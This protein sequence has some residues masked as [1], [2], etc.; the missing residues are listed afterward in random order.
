MIMTKVSLKPLHKITQL[1]GLKAC[2]CVACGYEGNMFTMTFQLDNAD[3]EEILQD[4]TIIFEKRVPKVYISE[5]YTYN[6]A[7]SEVL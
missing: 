7:G 2:N 4:L 5:P 1:K 6:N 3:A